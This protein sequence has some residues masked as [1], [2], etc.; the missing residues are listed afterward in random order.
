MELVNKQIEDYC[1]SFTTQEP[2]IVKELIRASEEDLEYT[3]MLSGRQVGM[4]LNMLVRISKAKRVLEVGTFTGYSA[5]MM[6]D[7]LQNDGELIT[8]ELNRRYEKISR[9]YFDREPYRTKIRQVIG[10]ALDV[11]PGLEGMFDL[12]YLD[13][14]KIN[15]PEYWKLARRKAGTGSLIVLDNMLWGGRVLN[16]LE[17]KEMAIHQ[18][19]E[20][21]KH[22][23]DVHQLMLPLRDGITI[24]QVIQ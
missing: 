16:A 10:N 19:S 5:L 7:A 20:M 17:G 14:D 1:K 6:A 13:A 8:I 23:P 22:D 21:I 15:Y 2:E 4:L 12:I 11:I 24:V 18:T 3:D 9:P